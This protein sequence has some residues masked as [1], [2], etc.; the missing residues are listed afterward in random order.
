MWI[1]YLESNGLVF[2][3][4]EKLRLFITDLSDRFPYLNK[5]DK[6]NIVNFLPQTQ[7]DLYLLM[8]NSSGF[9]QISNSDKEAQALLTLIKKYK[10]KH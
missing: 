1:D 8:K 5:L 4:T 7:G 10:N 3:S 9:S 6:M 2:G